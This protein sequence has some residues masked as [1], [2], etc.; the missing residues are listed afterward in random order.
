MTCR[1]RVSFAGVF[2][3]GVL[4][5]A[6]IRAG[7]SE[8]PKKLPVP[9]VAKQTEAEELIKKI[10]KEDYAQ[11]GAEARIKLA[12][13]LLESAR[14]TNDDPAAKFVLQREARDLAAGA[15]TIALALTVV[16]EMLRDF[17]IDPA[18]AA[19]NV[20]V[21]GATAVET[22]EQG[23]DLLEIALEFLSE[24][25]AADNFATA[26][27]LVDAA[28]KAAKKTEAA[29]LVSL[30]KER[31]AEVERL[32]K[33]FAKVK[34]LLDKIKDK[35]TALDD[36]KANDELGRYYGLVRGHWDRALPFLA[37]STSADLKALA[38][39]DLAKP[40]AAKQQA[41]LGDAWWK[42]AQTE[43]GMA[44]LHLKQRAVFWYTQALPDLTGLVA[45]RIQKLV[46]ET[47][48][49]TSKNLPSLVLPNVKEGTP[50]R[51]SW[52][53]AHVLSQ[54]FTPDGRHLLVGSD[55][56]DG[57]RL[58]DLVAAKE[59][60]RFPG[61]TF[62][63]HNVAIS[64]TG[65]R[66]LSGG[67]DKLLHLWDMTTGKELRVFEG[68]TAPIYAVAFSPDGALAASAGGD[69]VIRLWDVKSGEEVRK[70]T[71]HTEGIFSLT[72]SPDGKYLLSGGLD[73]TTRLWSVKTWKEVRKFEGGGI[74]A[75]FTP[76]SR[77]LITSSED[78]SLRLWHIACDKE[79]R[80]FTG[81]NG[82]LNWVSLSGDGRRVLGTD[83]PNRTLHLWD[84]RTGKH[85]Q[86]LVADRPVNRGVLSPDGRYAA[87]GTYRGFTD[88]WKL[89]K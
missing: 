74:G 11:V 6:N 10:F 60:K 75:M 87:C 1:L 13:L 8:S 80:R 88:V 39:K 31:H 48:R 53:N 12:G 82:N 20:F 64:T 65:S 35:A 73:K 26:Q 38:Q 61:S 47:P 42:A 22:P 72:F 43:K 25:L 50:L 63:V 76:D 52:D 78:K 34:P 68:H 69:K 46:A 19:V 16:D 7:G 79:L 37:A 30:V 3:L 28:E 55:S 45:M 59:L 32:N 56:G 15:G 24:A 29:S 71:G 84:V 40:K 41:A 18:E 58:Y 54:A 77:R 23:A 49:A 44:Q 9:P 33:E 86:Q 66:A 62:W 57:L 4:T 70:L 27:K 85:L 36:P 81:A 17:A 5:C 14:D 67:E 83:H 2:L 89:L 21:R 51:F